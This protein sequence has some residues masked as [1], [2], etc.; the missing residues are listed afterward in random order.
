VALL[1]RRRRLLL[2]GIVLGLLVL[3]GVL[4]S[5]IK[6]SADVNS[7]NSGS[8]QVAL[9]LN[10]DTPRPKPTTLTVSPGRTTVLNESIA[11]EVR[12]QRENQ[13]VDRPDPPLPILA[14]LQVIGPP[15]GL[16][17]LAWR[18]GRRAVA[19]PLEQVNLGVYK[20]AMPLEMVTARSK[21]FVF[22]PEQAHRHLFG[23]ERGDF[24]PTKPV[25][26]GRPRAAG[27]AAPPAG[28]VRGAFQRVR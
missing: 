20:G 17:V 8:G 22:T 16:A 3:F 10:R 6:E 24:V 1:R 18:Y 2:A 21:G 19:G 14:L 12:Q 7:L 5:S 26:V 9:D 23:R 4:A 13:H 15:I 28:P 27:P 25:V 11:P